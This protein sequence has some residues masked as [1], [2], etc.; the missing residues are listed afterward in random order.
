MSLKFAAVGNLMALSAFENHTLVQDRFTTLSPIDTYDPL[1]AMIGRGRRAEP[2]E[3][4][5]EE[6][7]ANQ[8]RW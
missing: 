5:S 8:A 7:P 3:P 2:A 4:K 6:R 1:L